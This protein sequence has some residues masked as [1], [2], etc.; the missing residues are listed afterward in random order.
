MCLAAS[1]H[2]GYRG[3]FQG[4]PGGYQHGSGPGPTG[5]PMM[6]QA[7]YG[8]GMGSNNAPMMRHGMP[9]PSQPATGDGSINVQNP[10]SDGQA[11][12]GYPR[13][14]YGMPPGGGYDGRAGQYHGRPPT[15]GFDSPYSG[16]D[17]G[18]Y[19]IR[20]HSDGPGSRFVTLLLLLLL[21]FIYYAI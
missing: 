5:D 15:E 4:T 21:L 9:P 10:F 13:P 19:P 1:A 18:P 16:Q 3:Q 6:M 14:G 12:G 17:A 11:P 8:S 7:P 20:P 2:D